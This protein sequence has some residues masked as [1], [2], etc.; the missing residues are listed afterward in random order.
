MAIAKS[1]PGDP[2]SASI[3]KWLTARKWGG[4]R[5]LPAGMEGL[6]QPRGTCLSTHRVAQRSLGWHK[7]S[8]GGGGCSPHTGTKPSPDRLPQELGTPRPGHTWTFPTLFPISHISRRA[9]LDGHGDRWY[10]RGTSMG[11]R[12]GS[13]LGQMGGCQG[14]PRDEGTGRAGVALRTSVVPP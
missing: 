1:Q 12:L 2:Q 8:W 6:S 9:V 7:Q 14:I 10:G 13:V 5:R 11:K 3:L 4:R